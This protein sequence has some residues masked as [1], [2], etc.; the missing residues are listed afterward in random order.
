MAPKRRLSIVADGPGARPRAAERAGGGRVTGERPAHA[1]GTPVR[2]ALLP[3]QR[4]ELG[5]EEERA[6]SEVLRSGWLGTGPVTA[7]FERAFAE[8][9]GAAHAVAVSSWTAGMHLLLRAF[10]IG[11]GDEVVTAAITFPATV[12]AILHAGARPVLADVR[13]DLLTLDAASVE[14]CL[15]PRTRALLPVHLYGW[16][17]DMAPLRAL[18]ERHGLVVLEDAAHALGASL[19]GRAAGTL[20]DGAS[21]SFYVTKNI[22]T[23]EGGM[24]TTERGDLV[25]RLRTERLHG[26]DL[27]ASRR[28]GRAYAHWESVSLGY[29]YNLN[30]LESALG[31]AQL[32]KLE[33]F[34]EVR[35][36]LDARYRRL[37]APLG[38][39]LRPVPGPEDAET[40]AH[41]FP[42][43]L[44][45]ERLGLDRDGMLQALLAENVGVGVHFRALPYHRH[46]REALG[47]VP[48]SVPVASAASERLLSLPLH[49]RMT[50]ADQDD[51]VA[52]LARIVRWYAT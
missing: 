7:R 18:A 41:L 38:A 46:V 21:F 50:E 34:L 23:G 3:F 43:E 13:P 44:A 36:R 15:T 2:D 31:L 11:P 4:P 19:G 8:R 28:E 35:R 48:E 9:L 47:A 30:D 51:V 39:W 17:C 29:K 49:T 27:D 14:A 25:E 5:V 37:L 12:N 45:T 42:V 32:G 52:A 40:A 1:G 24:V 6:A 22:T 10:G 20:G 16:P 26:V 33:R